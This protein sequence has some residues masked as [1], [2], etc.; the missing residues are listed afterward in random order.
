MVRPRFLLGQ[1]LV[2]DLLYFNLCFFFLHCAR[3]S[4]RDLRVLVLA[5]LTHNFL[6]FFFCLLN[7][8]RWKLTKFDQNGSVLWCVFELL[9]FRLWL[10]IV[11]LLLSLFNRS[12]SVTI[13]IRRLCITFRLV[14]LLLTLTVFFIHATVPE[15]YLSQSSHQI[16]V[17]RFDQ[18]NILHALRTFFCVN[19]SSH[20]LMFQNAIWAVYDLTFGT[21]AWVDGHLL[22]NNAFGLL[23]QL[24]FQVAF[25]TFTEKYMFLVQEQVRLLYVTCQL[26]DMIVE[27]KSIAEETWVFLSLSQIRTW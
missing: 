26:I 2:K 3:H 18:T 24:S 7:W 25:L 20:F 12:H 1:T 4:S 14:I 19:S 8:W 22:A 17:D 27:A 13:R 9:E 6:F 15:F 23:N 10:L 21:L 11:D 16:L 5:C